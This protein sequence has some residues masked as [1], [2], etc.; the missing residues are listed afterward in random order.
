MNLRFGNN[1]VFKTK[2]GFWSSMI[3]FLVIACICLREIF[4]VLSEE[5]IGVKQ[6]RAHLEKDFFEK[7]NKVES[8]TFGYA[9][10]G[11]K[12]IHKHIKVKEE[13]YDRSGVA[14]D[15]SFKV[16]DCSD[17]IYANLASNNSYGVPENLEIKCF[18]IP[19]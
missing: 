14:L 16:H 3:L 2:C 18:K 11:H 6:E 7:N 4:S 15:H 19:I 17:F 9:F 8:F 12:D 10:A 13:F 5:V 1:D